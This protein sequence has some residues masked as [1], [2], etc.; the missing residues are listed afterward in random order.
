MIPIPKVSDCY[1]YNSEGH[2]LRVITAE[3]MREEERKKKGEFTH[4][5]PRMISIEELREKKLQEKVNS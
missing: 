5:S 2:L 3:E 1:I 4:V